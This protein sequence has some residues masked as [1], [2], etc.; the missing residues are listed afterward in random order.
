MPKRRGLRLAA[1]YKLKKRHRG[2]LLPSDLDFKVMFSACSN[3]SRA[4][5]S[6]VLVFL[7]SITLLVSNHRSNRYRMY[8]LVCIIA[9]PRVLNHTF[10]RP[11]S[12]GALTMSLDGLLYKNLFLRCNS[13]GIP[14]NSQFSTWAQELRSSCNNQLPLG[15]LPPQSCG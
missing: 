4:F 6:S 13:Q 3:F 14:S 11:V 10:M 5:S 8:H 12:I 9:E 15:L 2:I 7:H 1:S